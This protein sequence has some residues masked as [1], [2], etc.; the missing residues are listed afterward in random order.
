[1]RNLR[2]RMRASR[3]PSATNI[4]SAMSSKSGT[5]MAQGLMKADEKSHCLFVT[6][7]CS[8]NPITRQ[9]GYMYR[10]VWLPFYLNI[11][12]QY[13]TS[14]CAL[15]RSLN[16]YACNDQ[17]VHVNFFF[18]MQRFATSLEVHALPAHTQA[19]MHPILPTKISS[20]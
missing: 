13:R 4:I 14:T 9:P 7:C 19:Q 2:A 20:C 15:F 5:T 12:T 8:Y 10:L 16:A 11:H 17:H 18:Y 6:T 3:N 1:M